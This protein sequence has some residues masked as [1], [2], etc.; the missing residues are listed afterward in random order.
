MAPAEVSAPGTGVGGVVW[1]ERGEG[2]CH[3]ARFGCR[4]GMA[5][6]FVSFWGSVFLIND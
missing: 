3:E 4:Q 2:S 6:G 5:D 1:V